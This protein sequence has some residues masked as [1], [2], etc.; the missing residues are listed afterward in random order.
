MKS[1]RIRTILKFVD[2]V[3]VIDD[4][5]DDNDDDGSRSA[6]KRKVNKTQVRW[7]AEQL[8]NSL[9]SPPILSIF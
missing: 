7:E 9:L 8:V 2:N 1:R 4:D 3:D 6:K 5:D